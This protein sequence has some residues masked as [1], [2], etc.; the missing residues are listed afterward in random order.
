MSGKV[1]SVCGRPL[2]PGE[3]RLNERRMGSGLKKSRYLCTR[4]R[5]MDY[6]AY[7]ST[8]KRLIDKK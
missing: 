3:A 4:C 2:S 1:C 8:M 5:Q 6:N 7:V